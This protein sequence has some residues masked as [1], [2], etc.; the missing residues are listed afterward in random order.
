[1]FDAKGRDFQLYALG[2]EKMTVYYLADVN[3]NKALNKLDEFTSNF[4][5]ILKFNTYNEALNYIFKNKI[6]Y[7]NFKPIDEWKGKKK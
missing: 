6:E 7:V 1:M 3:T 4:E 2:V 5:D